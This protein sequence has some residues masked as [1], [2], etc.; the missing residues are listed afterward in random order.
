[1]KTRNIILI[2]AAILFNIS[3]KQ[4]T[5]VC[6]D[7]ILVDSLATEAVNAF[8]SGDVSKALSLY[9]DDIVFINGNVTMNTKDSLSNGFR[10]MFEHMKNF[11]YTNG[12][13]SVSKDMIFAEGMF[14]FDWNI[15]NHTSIGKGVMVLVYIKQPDNSWKITYCKENHGD[16]PKK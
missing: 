6:R 14:T 7:Q 12:I 3:C 2:A 10:Y 11:N 9:T 8:N 13:S 15:D 4:K 16:I 1:M 5:E